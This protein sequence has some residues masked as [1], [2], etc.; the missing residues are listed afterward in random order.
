MLCKKFPE[1]FSFGNFFSNLIQ[2]TLDF[3]EEMCYISVM[4]GFLL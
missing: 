1:S 3:R 4:K 2:K